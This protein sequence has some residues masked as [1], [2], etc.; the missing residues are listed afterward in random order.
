M[1]HATNC[2]G[3]SL[4][5]VPM[6]DASGALRPS[7]PAA[8]TGCGYRSYHNVCVTCTGHMC[9]PRRSGYAPRPPTYTLVFHHLASASMNPTLS[10]PNVDLELG[11]GVL[12]LSGGYTLYHSFNAHCEKC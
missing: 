9:A 10:H 1:H 8:A 5:L 12:R 2:G 3:E 6:S 7:E 4:C 11:N